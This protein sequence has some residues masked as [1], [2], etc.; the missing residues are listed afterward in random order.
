MDQRKLQDRLD[1]GLNRAARVIGRS[2]D[3]FRPVGATDPISSETRYLRLPAAFS[4]L[5]GS[6]SKAVGYGQALWRGYFDRA[7]TR[8]GDYLVQD[9]GTWFIASQQD[10]LPIVCVKTN[11][12]LSVSRIL[13]PESGAVYGSGVPGSRITILAEWPGSMF[14]VKSGEVPRS[15]LPTDLPAPGWT[16]LLPI[17]HDQVIRASDI[18]DDASGI[19]SIVL[20]AELSDLGWRL[21][22]RQIST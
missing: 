12:I 21:N 6:F 7:Y 1:W 14:S 16:C 20:S 5:D 10:L 3:A 13:P 9:V 19:S 2:T 11:C 8:A 4:A 15:G 22:I 17:G 18:V